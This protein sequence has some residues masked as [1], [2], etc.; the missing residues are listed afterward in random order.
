MIEFSSSNEE[1]QKSISMIESNADEW[2]RTETS[3]G[4]EVEQRIKA[5]HQEISQI[6]HE[7]EKLSQDNSEA[8]EKYQQQITTLNAEIKVN[9]DAIKEQHEVR[10]SIHS[11][12]RCRC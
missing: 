10:Q 7:F 11:W 9:N 3:K 1:M 8:I 12:H 4:Q 5:M 6:G 2:R